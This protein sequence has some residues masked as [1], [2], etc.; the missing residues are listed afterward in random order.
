VWGQYEFRYSKRFD[1]ITVTSIEPLRALPK[2]AV[3][4][5]CDFVGRNIV[6]GTYSIDGK[7]P[8]ETE[9]GGQLGCS[10]T[11]IRETTRLLTAKGMVNPVRHFGTAVRHHQNWNLLDPDVAFWHEPGSPTIEFIREELKALMAAVLPMAAGGAARAFAEVQ[12]VAEDEAEDEAASPSTPE[13]IIVMIF[14]T[15]GARVFQ[16][17]RDLGLH[18]ARLREP[19]S[20]KDSLYQK[21]EAAV[22]EGRP[23]EAKSC[24]EFLLSH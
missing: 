12:A 20:F 22:R 10:R 1:W 3:R 14:D 16:N 17:A 9:L 24:A 21:L 23:D 11:V 18:F 15:A 4:D 7:L 19:D 13:T 5:A 6:A 2:S 8:H